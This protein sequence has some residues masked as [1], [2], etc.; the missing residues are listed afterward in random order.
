MTKN[1]SQNRGRKRVTERERVAKR[2]KKKNELQREEEHKEREST[3]KG[4]N[5]FFMW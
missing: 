4:R 1:I 3:A 5:E 2:W